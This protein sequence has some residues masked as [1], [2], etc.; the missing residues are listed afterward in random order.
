MKSLPSTNNGVWWTA[1]I[2]FGKQSKNHLKELC[3]HTVTPGKSQ[4]VQTSFKELLREQITDLVRSHRIN[5]LK[6]FSQYIYVIHFLTW[7]RLIVETPWCHW[8]WN[9]IHV[10]CMYRG[11]RKYV[12][13]SELF[14]PHFRCIIKST[15]FIHAILGKIKESF[16]KWYTETN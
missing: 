9:K 8:E 4:G 3:H 13:H 10:L 7:N 12:Y 6:S 16:T 1:K 11:H 5:F 15:S 2:I 14:S